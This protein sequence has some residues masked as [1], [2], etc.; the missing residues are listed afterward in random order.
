MD[1]NRLIASIPI[2]RLVISEQ[3]RLDYPENLPTC[4]GLK[5]N[6]FGGISKKCL[7]CLNYLNFFRISRQWEPKDVL[8]CTRTPDTIVVNYDY[9]DYYAAPVDT[10]SIHKY[11]KHI[12]PV[13][14]KLYGR[15]I[16]ARNQ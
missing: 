10:I 12:L 9:I 6:D 14:E 1:L 8:T 2:D 5:S 11:E 4:P 15:I 7:C 13:L 16:E 3:G